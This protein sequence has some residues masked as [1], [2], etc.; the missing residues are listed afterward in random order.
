M[1]V[2]SGLP[3]SCY[4]AYD[5]VVLKQS[6][7]DMAPGIISGLLLMPVTSA[8]TDAFN[9]VKKVALEE[10]VEKTGETS[11]K[12]RLVSSITEEKFV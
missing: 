1:E 9:A 10:A 12:A 7:L 6:F 2:E 5:D 11:A 4:K 8:L 3:E